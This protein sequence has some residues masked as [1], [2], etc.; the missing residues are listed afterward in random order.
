MLPSFAGRQIVGCDR[1]CQRI[2]MT[3]A[4]RYRNR[5]RST[6]LATESGLLIGSVEQ[7][8]LAGPGNRGDF[9]Q[10]LNRKAEQSI[11]TVTDWL[12]KRTARRNS[13]CDELSVHQSRGDKTAIELFMDGVQGLPAAIRA[14][15][16]QEATLSR[17]KAGFPP[18]VP[19]TGGEPR[20][21]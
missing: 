2:P 10:I 16:C 18:L 21:L 14:M 19:K 12:Q 6:R 8:A 5:C 17:G 11:H 4:S 20:G 15:L 9:G 1:Q 3:G 13:V 7:L